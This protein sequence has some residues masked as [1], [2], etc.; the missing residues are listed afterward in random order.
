MLRLIERDG[1]EHAA[2]LKAAVYELE[3]TASSR[4]VKLSATSRLK[5]FAYAALKKGG[6]KLV[7]SGG[8]LLL[9][10]LKAKLGI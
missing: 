9:A 2:E 8:E 1:R 4:D 10:Y 7:D 3:D 5:A 6:E